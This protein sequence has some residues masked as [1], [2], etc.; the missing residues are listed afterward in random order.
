MKRLFVGFTLVCAAS[1]QA[2][3]IKV[4]CV[5]DSIALG[6]GLPNAETS[7]YP[8]QLQ[9]ILGYEFE[10]KNFAFANASISPDS[11]A[12]YAAT[13]Q[14]KDA[15]KFQPNVVLIH[16][17]TYDSQPQ[18]WSQSWK[19]GIAYQDMIFQFRAF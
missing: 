2:L 14:F 13:P 9:K 6:T 17:G 12:S 5:G 10:V 11:P 19:F 18:L 7:S 16:L 8:A 3:P 1:A 4:A 15:L